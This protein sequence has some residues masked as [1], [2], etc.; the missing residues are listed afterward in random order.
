MDLWPAKITE[1]EAIMKP[2]PFEGCF[3]SHKHV[4]SLADEYIVLEDDVV[5]QRRDILQLYHLL[6]D[7]K[8]FDIVYLGG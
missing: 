2:N 7:Y 8:D 3:E 4:A 1:V 5:P 6:E